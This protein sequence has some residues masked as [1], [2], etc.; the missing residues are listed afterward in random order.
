MCLQR[1]FTSLER[2]IYT[3]LAIHPAHAITGN[4]SFLPVKPFFLPI[5][6]GPLPTDVKTSDNETEKTRELLKY[7]NRYY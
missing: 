7:C 2:A 1:K 3:S 4:T 6:H 5:R